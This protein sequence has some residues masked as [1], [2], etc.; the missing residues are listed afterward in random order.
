MQ[1]AK[2]IEAK[3][4]LLFLFIT[5][6][7]ITRIVGIDNDVV[8]PDA[9]NWHFRS[10]QFVVG[11]KHLQ[12]EKTFQHYQPG[13]TLMWIMGATV[14]VTK[15]LSGTT[16]YD[17]NNFLV[18]HQLSKISLVFVQLGLTI[19]LMFLLSKLWGF[20]KAFLVTSLFS[21]EPF[22]I[23]NS[24]LLH[25]DVL[26]TLLLTI[27]LVLS[28]LFIK[29]GKW[30][31]GVLAGLFLGFATLTKSVAVGGVLFAVFV[32]G[33][34]VWK[35]YGVKQAFKYGLVVLISSVLTFVMF[36]PA[37]W[38]N[39]NEVLN[40]MYDGIAR[41]G[42][43]RGHGQVL[44][45]KY[46]RDAG[47]LFYPIIA[48]VKLSPFLLFGLLLS[49]FRIRKPKMSLFIY[50]SVFMVGYLVVMSVATKK[51]DRYLLPVYPYFALCSYFGYLYVK[52]MFARVVAVILFVI[53]VALP[54]VVFHPYQF[55]YVNPLL[56]SPKFVHE[57][58]LAQKPFGVGIPVLKRV[59]LRDYGDYPA[60]GF[61][62][63]KPMAAI[64]MNSRVFD[65]RV[66]GTKRYDLIILGVNEEMPE[67]VLTSEHEFVHKQ[68]VIINGLE[69]WK[70]YVKQN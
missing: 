39:A 27:G 3:Y 17:M 12:L 61:I 55:T 70:I 56:G 32:G 21:F 31:Y 44:F 4:L 30:L 68:S 50:L 20:N 62:D 57:K 10:E 53:T 45:G 40:L 38:V 18:F 41:V 48:L 59:I 33:A 37:L 8:N 51:I 25:L 47:W 63:R 22:F 5:L 19:Y 67:K 34:M 69:Y 66:D 11:L 7:L 13:T 64:Y 2:R 6:F 42:I 65:I 52:N 9:T 43:R 23:A 60:L 58:I 36:M 49:L 46:S 14:E 1:W 29:K 35:K 54:F 24:R 15:Q 26:L 28:Y 16:T